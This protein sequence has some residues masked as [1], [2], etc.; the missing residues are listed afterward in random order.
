MSGKSWHWHL[1]PSKSPWNCHS[2][3]IGIK[4]VIAVMIIP[5]AVIEPMS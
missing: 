5:R 2:L 3:I 1:I 4:P